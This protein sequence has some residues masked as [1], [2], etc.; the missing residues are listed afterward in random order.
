MTVTTTADTIKNILEAEREAG[1]PPPRKKQKK[2]AA[3]AKPQH[4]VNTSGGGAASPPSLPPPRR[5]AAP[6]LRCRSVAAPLPPLP[7]ALLASSSL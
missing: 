6:L 5:D 4:V 1:A 7:A 2:G 3:A